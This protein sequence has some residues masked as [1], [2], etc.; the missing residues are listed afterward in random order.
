MQSFLLLLRS[1]LSSYSAVLS[2]RKPR[3][4]LWSLLLTSSVCLI[5]IGQSYALSVSV[6]SGV[7]F[8]PAHCTVTLKT[9]TA[10]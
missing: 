3:Q 1:G 7:A 10:T 6:C 8:P 5:R 9:L 4:S 2:K